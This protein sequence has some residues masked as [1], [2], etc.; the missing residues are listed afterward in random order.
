MFKNV[1]PKFFL[2]FFSR[3][4]I[5]CRYCLCCTYYICSYTDIIYTLVSCRIFSSN[6]ICFPHFFAFSMFHLFSGYTCSSLRCIRQTVSACRNVRV[7]RVDSGAC[8]YG[9]QTCNIVYAYVYQYLNI[10]RMYVEIRI[11]HTVL[12]QASMVSNNLTNLTYCFL[13][14]PASNGS[15]ISFNFNN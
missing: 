1:G 6:I 2:V 13:V 3:F 8:G 12:Y 7:Q 4:N 9:R 14:R 15:S 11:S 5:Y 10:N